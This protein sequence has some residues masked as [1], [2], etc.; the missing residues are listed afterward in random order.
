MPESDLGQLL[1]ESATEVLETMFFTSTLSEQAPP[2]PVAGPGI[3]ATLSF[4]GDPP[5]R[6]GLRLPAGTARK[7][8]AS[9]LGKNEAEVSEIQI[10]EVVSELA[11]MLC[12]SVLSR[13]EKE[14]MFHLSHPEIDPAGV[15][16]RCSLKGFH[17]SLQMEEGTI[18]LWLDLEQPQ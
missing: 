3:C 15:G 14:T 16:R 2:E 11:N 7:I 1:S 10:G 4:Q 5:G 12:G 9:F 17:K 13:L 6:F 18:G 8:A